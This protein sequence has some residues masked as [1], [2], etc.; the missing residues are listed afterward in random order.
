M[1]SLGM[2]PRTPLS[3]HF[4]SGLSGNLSSKYIGVRIYPLG[5]RRRSFVQHWKIAKSNRYLL[6]ST[7]PRNCVGIHNR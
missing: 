3:S 6:K 1:Q 4:P 2:Q 5:R 7:S